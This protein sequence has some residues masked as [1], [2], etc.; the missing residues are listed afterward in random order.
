M[1]ADRWNVPLSIALS[2]VVFA[3]AMAPCYRLKDPF[4]RLHVLAVAGYGAT[5]A[6]AMVNV[7]AARTYQPHLRPAGLGW[8][9]G[10]GRFGAVAG[11][12]IT[13][14][15]LASGTA[16]QSL[17]FFALVAL[18]GAAAAVLAARATQAPS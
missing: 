7:Q 2:F 4:A 5:G 17:L 9:L 1:V 3:G 8:S 12:S 18:A 13:G 6:F 16:R 15:I 11:P 14:L 10:V